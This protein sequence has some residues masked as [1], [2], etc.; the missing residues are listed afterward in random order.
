VNARANTGRR[1]R[2]ALAAFVLTAA[3]A[4]CFALPVRAL[5]PATVLTVSTPKSLSDLDVESRQIQSQM[6]VLESR[7]TVASRKCDTA[8]VQLT[9]IDLGLTQTRLKLAGA[10]AALDTEQALLAARAA[11][12]YKIGDWG[13]LDAF[14]HSGSFSDL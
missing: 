14:A 1:A 9:A 5:G 12:I 11:T 6:R 2:A 4:A 10:Q 8:A 7:L 3:G 13:W